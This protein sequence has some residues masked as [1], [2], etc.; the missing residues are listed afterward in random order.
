MGTGP[1][2]P[3]AT[4][5]SEEVPSRPRRPPSPGE[6]EAR[7]RSHQTQP[8][9]L[10]GIHNSE[11]SR[12]TPQSIGLECPASRMLTMVWRGSDVRRRGFSSGLQPPPRVVEFWRLS[13]LRRCP[14]LSI[15]ESPRPIPRAVAVRAATARGEPGWD[16]ARFDVSS[17]AVPPARSA[18]QEA[19]RACIWTVSALRASRSQFGGVRGPV[20][21]CPRALKLPRPAGLVVNPVESRRQCGPTRRSDEGFPRSGS[22]SP[23]RR[24]RLHSGWRRAARSRAPAAPLRA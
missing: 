13:V 5:T 19:D 20:G 3:F 1:P 8:S 14:G 23:P 18:S 17:E 11:L 6:D 4:L 10:S 7:G 24:P 2:Y 15:G 22:P 12:V 9:E 16:E 21:A